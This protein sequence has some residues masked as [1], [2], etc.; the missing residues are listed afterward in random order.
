LMDMVAPQR[1]GEIMVFHPLGGI[2]SFF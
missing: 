1:L 2:G